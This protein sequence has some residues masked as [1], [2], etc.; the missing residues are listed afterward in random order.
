[1][2]EARQIEPSPVSRAV[3]QVL[4]EG[5]TIFEGVYPQDEVDFFR[6]I[7]VEGWKSVGSPPLKADSRRPL[8]SNID[9]GPTG[10]AVLEL[11]KRHAE[12]AARLFKPIIVETL[13]GV[14]GRDMRCE[15]AAGML[16]DFDRPFFDWH[17][18]TDGIDDARI[19]YKRQYRRFTRAE[20]VTTLLYLDDINDDNGTLL[21]YPRKVDDP[22]EPPYDVRQHDWDGMVELR[23]RRGSF[24]ILEQNTWHAVRP[25]RVPGLRTFVG[26]FFAAADATPS[27]LS[28]SPLPLLP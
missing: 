4:S 12:A 10:M 1:M 16:S 3:S 13:R 21:I 14:L 22:T 19:G 6:N 28:E 9:V 8:A 24:V 2:I 18:H 7:L 23:C 20:R 27:P 25:K 15:L 26:C 11:T 5:W 17:I